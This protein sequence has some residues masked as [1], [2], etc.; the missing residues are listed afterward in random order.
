MQH[1]SPVMNRIMQMREM[2]RTALTEKPRMICWQVKNDEESMVDG[3][4]LMEE[5]DEHAE[6]P[7]L[8]FQLNAEFETYPTFSNVL[9][10]QLKSIHADTVKYVEAK[11]MEGM[12]NWNPVYEDWTEE[13][14]QSPEYFLD[15]MRNFVSC[16]ED[17]KYGYWV[18]YLSPSMIY[19]YKEWGI[20]LADLLKLGI[21]DNL[22]FMVRDSQDYEALSFLEVDHAKQVQFIKTDLNMY[23]AMKQEAKGGQE[24][25]PG[26]QFRVAFIEMAEEAGKKNLKG[27]KHWGEQCVQIAQ[28]MSNKELESVAY[29]SIG[30]HLFN[31][32]KPKEALKN[33]GNALALNDLIAEEKDQETADRVAIQIYAGIGSVYFIHKKYDQASEVYESMA[34]KGS[35]VKDITSE[36]E[37]WRMKT[38]CDMQLRNTKEA[39]E[40]ALKGHQA[41]KQFPKGAVAMCP[42]NMGF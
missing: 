36:L 28:K 18:I 3:F 19:H 33:Y 27:L 7:E 26:V 13:Q 41:A 24:H 29:L 14:K 11:D 1:Q 38:F 12:E 6:F 16:L 9:V 21:P 17:Y 10:E 31:L 25:D 37:G 4:F 40:A 23:E 5:A 42:K 32:G 30:T 39:Y 8:F 22:L 20:W 35:A 34:L 15:N 2:W